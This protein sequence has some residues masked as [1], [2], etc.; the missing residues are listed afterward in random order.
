MSLKLIHSPAFYGDGEKQ[1]LNWWNAEKSFPCCSRML[2]QILPLVYPPPSDWNLI[3]MV[4]EHL[5]AVR[6]LVPRERCSLNL[7]VWN[8]FI[9]SPRGS[10]SQ[11][12]FLTPGQYLCVM[13]VHSITIASFTLGS[14]R[15]DP[16]HGSFRQ[17]NLIW[18]KWIY[19]N[20][21]S[22]G[23]CR[24]L[25]IY[26]WI[27]TLVTPIGFCERT[28]RKFSSIYCLVAVTNKMNG[29]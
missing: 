13:Y 25:W 28:T 5:R 9:G 3:R 2:C 1:D 12:I 24:K 11:I 20:R 15:K 27:S 4:T 22:K 19:V 14:K 21:P 6:P 18:S 26:A 29:F 23:E 17:E 8:Q 7:L 16:L 10:I